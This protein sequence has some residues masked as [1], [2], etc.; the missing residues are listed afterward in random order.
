[1]ARWR[2]AWTVVALVACGGKPKQP[3]TTIGEDGNACER[4]R[5]LEDFA[6]QVRARKDETR[7]CFDAFLTTKPGTKGRVVINYRVDASGTV[8]E[9]SQG[10]QDD[11]IQDEML[12]T[13]ISDVLKT[14][15]FA[16]SPSG[17][18]TRAYHQFE[19][20]PR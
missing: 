18:T 20:S 9:T 3:A 15:K 16:S 2:H 12:V 19:F 17:K 7:A 4:G 5:C 8:V 14:V 6:N 10:M 1:M 13:C 11:Q